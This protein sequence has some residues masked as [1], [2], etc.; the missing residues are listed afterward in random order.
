VHVIPN[1][2]DTEAIV[3]ADRLTPYRR[4]LG[5]AT[6]GG[7]VRRQRRVLP[8]ARPGDRGRPSALP[9][10]TF[11]VNG[12]GAARRSL[13]ASASGSPTCASPTS[14]EAD[15][16]PEVLATGDIHVVPLRAGLG[17][18]S[19]PSKTYS[20]L[21][22]GRPVVASIDPDTAVPTILLEASGGGVA[23]P[24]TA[25]RVHRG[26]PEPRRRPRTRGAPGRGRSCLG[27]A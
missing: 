24:R 13:E 12:D 4:E 11:L 18:V 1:F 7:A 5:S 15:R 8:V 10:V 19:V 26:D 17:R 23:V 21:A 6:A 16:L 3:P 14:A 2:V 9:D 20:I 27:G 22:A 25:R